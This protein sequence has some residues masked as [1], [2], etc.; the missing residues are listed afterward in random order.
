LYPCFVYLIDLKHLSLGDG[1]C[2]KTK[3]TLLWKA[4]VYVPDFGRQI[5]VLQELLVITL[6]FAHH[7]V[8][9]EL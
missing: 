4:V 3:L 2:L 5:L 8:F 1:T 6:K 9:A 7:F